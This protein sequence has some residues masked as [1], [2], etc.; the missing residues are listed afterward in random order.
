MKI[1]KNINARL[2]KMGRWIKET[3]W[4][5]PLLIV[6]GIFAI[7]F[8]I[9]KFQAWF[10]TMA[11]GTS[12]SYF[13]AYRLSLEN[14][15]KS[16]YDTEADLCTKSINDFS[17]KE[18]DNYAQA[19]AELS[20]SG[21]LGK[22]GEKYFL[23]FIQNDCTGCDNAANALE[24]LSNSWNTPNFKIDDSKAF[25]LWSINAD[26]ESTNDKDYTI[27]EKAKAFHRYAEK[28]DELDFWSRA[29][30]QLESADYKINS[31]IADSE[32]DAL[33]NAESNEWK[34]PM[35]FLVDW[36]EAAFNRERFGVS[37]VLFGFEQ[38]STDYERAT[39]LQKMWNHISVDGTADLENPFRNRETGL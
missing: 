10:Q 28:F 5:Q 24:I 31:N 37:E 3:A 1:L 12:D 22:Y 25:K 20:Q 39:I 6:G 36:S 23:V 35:I 33:A 9:S 8:S 16:G 11:V 7:I 13:T 2:A 18:Y 19:Y 4:V 17:F 32:Y 34:T 38:G 15:G 30:G 21:T 26:E 14:E 27:P 29:A